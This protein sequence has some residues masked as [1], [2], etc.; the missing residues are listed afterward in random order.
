[1]RAI[2]RRNRREVRH[3]RARGKLSGTPERPR[4]AVYRSLRHI[5]AQLVDDS[6]GKTLAA[7]SSQSPELKGHLKHGGNREAA[8][9]VGELIARRAGEKG[10]KRACFD[11]AGFKYHGAVSAVAEAA[12]KAGLEF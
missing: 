12:R 1:M 6:A 8:S 2:G 3:N 4:L 10:I 5:Y 7:A 11:R 9:K